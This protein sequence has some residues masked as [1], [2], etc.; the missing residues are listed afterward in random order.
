VSAWLFRSPS[1]T[2]WRR[3]PLKRNRTN[4]GAI[5]FKRPSINVGI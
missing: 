2:S 3:R 5:C 4:I 1:E